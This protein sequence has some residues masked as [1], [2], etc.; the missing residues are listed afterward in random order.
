MALNVK[1]LEKWK[2]IVGYEG[3]YEISN[4]GRVKSCE[5]RVVNHQSGSTRLIQE[6]ILKITSK[7]SGGY[8][9]VFLSK[10]GKRELFYIHRLVA[11]H[12]VPNPKNKPFVNHLDCNKQNNDEENLTFV[13]RVENDRHAFRHGLKVPPVLRGERNHQSKLN[14]KQVRVVRHLHKINPKLSYASIGR[15]FNVSRFIIRSICKKYTWDHVI[16]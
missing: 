10:D 1:E 15:L 9:M 2:Q 13:T 4:R 8:F 6:K 16:I 11:E 7:S 12:F 3:F 14:E 5:R